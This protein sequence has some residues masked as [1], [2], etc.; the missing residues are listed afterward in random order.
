MPEQE[1]SPSSSKEK[2]IMY[3][4]AAFM[5]FAG[6][7]LKT[8]YDGSK[9]PDCSKQT[10]E[11]L[12]YFQK[13]TSDYENTEREKDFKKDQRILVLEKDS[14]TQLNQRIHL[15]HALDSVNATVKKVIIPNAN[16]LTNDKKE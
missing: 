3:A 4:I 6:G 8:V 14:I 16:K 15:Y 5:A 1:L 2:I 10:L 12:G 9:P 7:A 13:M 11:T